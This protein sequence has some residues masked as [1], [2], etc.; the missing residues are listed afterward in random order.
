MAEHIEI[1]RWTGIAHIKT[2]A[3]SDGLNSGVSVASEYG[4]ASNPENRASRSSG[5]SI[6][7][8]AHSRRCLYVPYVLRELLMLHCT[9]F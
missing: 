1:G 4:N 3:P 9:G 7:E 2:D 8:R 5:S 6:L